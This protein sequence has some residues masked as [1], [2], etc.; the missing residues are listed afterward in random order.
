MIAP[1]RI[2]EIADLVTARGLDEEAVTRLRAAFP[3]IHFTYCRDDDLGMQEPVL[4]RPGCNLYLVD[5]R[6]HCLRFTHNPEHATGL[7]LAEVE[8]AEEP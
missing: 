3:E 4:R 1:E 7:V 5:G 6:E 8:D 2:R